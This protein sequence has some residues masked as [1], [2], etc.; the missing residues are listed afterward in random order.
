MSAAAARARDASTS[1]TRS[2]NDIARPYGHTAIYIGGTTVVTTQGM[3]GARLP[4]AR[5]DL[6][7]F[8]NYLGWAAV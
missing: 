2:S 3:E 1:T 6:Y 7:S 5:R 4:V 8:S